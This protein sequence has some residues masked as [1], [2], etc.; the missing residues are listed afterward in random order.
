M[1]AQHFTHEAR[2]V[3]AFQFTDD[4]RQHL[5]SLTPAEGTTQIP[6][7]FDGKPTGAIFDQKTSTIRIAGYHK[8]GT[9]LKP[10]RWFAYQLNGKPFCEIYTPET[11]LKYKALGLTVEPAEAGQ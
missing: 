7:Q 8:K 1:K 5:L 9:N 10:D 2:T 3:K 4:F 11:F 6:I